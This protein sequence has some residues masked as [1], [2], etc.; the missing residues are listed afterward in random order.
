MSFSAPATI[1]AADAVPLSTS[2]TSGAPLSASPGA[3]LEAEIGFLEAAL[4]GHDDAVVEEDVADLDRRRQQ[5]ARI[6]AQVEHHALQ[7][8]LLSF[9]SAL[10]AL[11]QLRAGVGL[12]LAEADVR[13]A[14]L[15]HAPAHAGDADDFALQLDV[16]RIDLASRAR[17]RA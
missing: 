13:V 1:S 4:R 6:A 3:A 8:A 11:V 16:D 12:E 14:G 7:R 17:R 5:A 10:D 9:C 15:E 2:T